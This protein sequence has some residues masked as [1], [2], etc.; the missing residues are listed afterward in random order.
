MNNMASFICLCIGIVFNLFGCIGMIRLPDVYNRLQA[1]TKCVTLGTCSIL[2]GVLL[3]F[4]FTDAGV[5]SLVAIPILFFTS[6]AAAHA[7]IRGAYHFGIPLGKKSIRDDYK[8]AV[9]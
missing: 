8:D 4:G 1:A 5:K 6:T 9:K 2:L 7:L 3:H